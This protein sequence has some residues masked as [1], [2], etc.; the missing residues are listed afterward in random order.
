MSREIVEFCDTGQKCIFCG[1]LSASENLQ[2]ELFNYKAEDGKVVEL[3]TDVPVVSC[4]S[5]GEQYTD[6]RAA[7][8]RHDAVC[9]F[10]KRLTPSQLRAVREHYCYSQAQWSELT[11]IGLASIKRWESGALIQGQALDRF[12]R[13][14]S[15]ERGHELLKNARNLPSRSNHLLKTFRTNISAHTVRDA[16]AFQLRVERAA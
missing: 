14:I 16:S 5:C 2:P 13:L 3:R 4:S 8:A 11:G 10:L 1:A 15:D 7:D 9:R 12:V 6:D